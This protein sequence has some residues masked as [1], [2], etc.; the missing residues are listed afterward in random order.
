M[1]RTALALVAAIAL[2][3]CG[4]T[5]ADPYEVYLKNNPDPSVVYSR[6]F[7]E[8]LVYLDCVLGGPWKRG[9]LDQVVVDAYGCDGIEQGVPA[10]PSP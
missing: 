1:K 4:G 7:I 2:A 3:G 9:S 6:E 5:K 10:L 8:S